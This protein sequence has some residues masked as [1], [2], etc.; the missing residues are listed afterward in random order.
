MRIMGLRWRL[1][2]MPMPL[3]WVLGLGLPP[4]KGSGVVAVSSD[5]SLVGMVFAAAPYRRY[6][7]PAREVVEVVPGWVWFVIVCLVVLLVWSFW[8]QVGSSFV[9]DKLRKRLSSCESER[10]VAVNALAEAERRGRDR[11]VVEAEFGRVGLLPFFGGKAMLAAWF[12]AID[13]A[14]KR[15]CV[16]SFLL[17]HP[18]VIGRLDLAVGRGVDVRCVVCSSNEGP[19]IPSRSWVREVSLVSGRMHHKF[20]ICDEDY[21]L[22]GSANFT[23][24]AVNGNAESAVELVGSKHLCRIFLEEF[25]R[26]WYFSF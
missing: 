18:E 8:V 15:I 22:L 25:D 14:E 11:V 24:A 26:L 19:N 20:I 2:T 21:L 1:V 9:A 7:A 12:S 16:A 17:T 5:L 13:C 6:R 23:F 10:D 3:F 4:Q